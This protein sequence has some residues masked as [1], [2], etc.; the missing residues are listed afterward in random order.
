MPATYDKIATTTL[1][2]AQSSVTFSSISSIYT[3]LELVIV[4]QGSSAGYI[5]INVNGDT[6]TNYSRTIIYSTGSAVSAGGN[7]NLNRFLDG[8]VPATNF[9]L[10]NYKFINYSASTYKSVL[11]SQRPTTDIVTQ[12]VQLWRSTS[13]ITSMVIALDNAANFNAN[14]VF[15]LYG[16]KAA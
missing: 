8:W 6:G 9:S 4:G 13:A 5:K 16:I 12:A 1:G 3:D 2:S 15:T 14:S 7:A 11:S 10:T